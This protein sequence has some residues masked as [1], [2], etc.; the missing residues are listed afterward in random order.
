MFETGTLV[1]GR[2]LVEGLCSSA[3]GMGTILFVRDAQAPEQ[4]LVLKYCSHHAEEVKNRFRREVRVMQTLRGNP[5]VAPIKHANLDHVPPYFVMPYFE[6]GDLTQLIPRLRSNLAEA[7]FC[8]NR[9][10]DCIE[11]LHSQG[12]F[13]RDIKPQNFLVGNGTIVVSDLGLCTEHGSATAMTRSSQYGGTP[14]FMPP[15]FWNGGFKSA[16][17]QSDIFMLGV[18]I[19]NILA[20]AESPGDASDYIPPP[21]LVVIERACSPDR[22]RRYSSLAALRQ[23]LTLAFDTVLNRTSGTGGVL[24]AQQAIVDRWKS[25]RSSDVNEVEVFLRELEALQPNDQQR[26][27]KDLPTDFFQALASTPLPQGWLGAFL[28]S[29]MN[30]ASEDEHG[31]SFAEV[32]ASNMSLIFYSPHSTA[33][34]KAEALRTAI[35]SAERQS[36]FAAMDTCKAMIAS[37]VDQELSQRVVDVMLEESA[38]FLRNVDPL[39][40]KSGIIRQLVAQLNADSVSGTGRNQPGSNPFLD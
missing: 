15:E 4:R 29:Y 3:G 11:Q 17:A 12:I 22:T 35:V 13:H 30:M 10:I 7:E 1:D 36:R 32:I 26:V 8:F 24:G 20:D 39:A 28:R 6:R 21:L 38:S 19:L 5:H 25:T 31:W 9:M 34:E 23:S 2:F 16:D 14:G 37:V 27:C 18:S 40:C 33:E